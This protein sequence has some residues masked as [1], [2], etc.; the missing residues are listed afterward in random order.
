MVSPYI[1]FRYDIYV[2]KE[3][4]IFEAMALVHSRIRRVIFQEDNLDD[5]GLGGTGSETSVHC[6]PGTNHHYRVFR[7]RNSLSDHLYNQD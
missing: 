1:C 3:P 7:Y 4:G 5:G 2:T 6:L